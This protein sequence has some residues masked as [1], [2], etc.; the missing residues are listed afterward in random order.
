MIIFY[1]SNL[2]TVSQSYNYA[3]GGMLPM[4]INLYLLA[5]TAFKIFVIYFVQTSF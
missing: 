5:D 3:F 2:V 4:N 1:Q